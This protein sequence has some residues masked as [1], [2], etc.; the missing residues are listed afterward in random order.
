MNPLVSIIIP[1]YNRA[2]LVRETLDSV[3][4][5]TYE[6]WECIIVD[7][8]SIDETLNIIKNYE[9]KNKKFNLDQPQKIREQI[10]VGIME[11]NKVM[12]S[13]LYF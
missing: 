7:D 6:N 8:G 9:L 11:S 3:Q 12:V 4:I 10:A 5:Q 1:T 13:I 2:H